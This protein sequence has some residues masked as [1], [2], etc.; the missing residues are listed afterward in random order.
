MRTTGDAPQISVTVGTSH[1]DHAESPTLAFLRWKRVSVVRVAEQPTR[2]TPDA[3]EASE[4][5]KEPAK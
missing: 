5:A 1:H 3:E 4:R 2:P